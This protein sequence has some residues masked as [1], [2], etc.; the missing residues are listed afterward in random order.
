MDIAT[1]VAIFATRPL[2]QPS[3]EVKED[4]LQR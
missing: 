2:Q 3:I 1:K 4:P